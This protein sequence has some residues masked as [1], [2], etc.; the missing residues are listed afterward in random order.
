MKIK[1]LIACIVAGWLG[2]IIAVAL[3]PGVKVEGDFSESLKVLLLAGV[4]L[5]LINF[6]VKPI[7]NLITLPIRWL[8]FGLFSL[9]INMG[10]VW[11]IDLLFSEIEIVNLKALFLTSLLICLLNFFVPKFSKEK[12]D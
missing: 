11:G 7:I 1:G 10:I 6:F 2:L 4:V 3:V 9:V 12:K 5:G 8:T